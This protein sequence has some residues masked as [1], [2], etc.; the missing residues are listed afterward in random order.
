[1]SYQLSKTSQKR[2]IG[3]SPDLVKVICRALEITKVDFGI[4][5]YGGR[6]TPEQ[7]NALFNAGKSKLDG[8]KKLSN[9]QTGQAVDLFA[10]VDGAA[11]WDEDYLTHVAAAMLQAAS[12][13]GVKL[14]WGGFWRSFIDMPHFE[15]VQ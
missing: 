15:I 14:N 4:P 8:Y 5:A 10:Y 3:V 6:R 1:M 13:L 12:E 9:H 7:Q 11:T 2:L